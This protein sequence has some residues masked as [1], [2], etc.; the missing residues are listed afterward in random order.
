MSDPFKRP[1]SYVKN[2]PSHPVYHEEN[3]NAPGYVFS[4]MHKNMK[5]S[6]SSFWLVP[7]EYVGPYN[8]SGL[9][10][11]ITYPLPYGK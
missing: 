6:S 9:N 5:E 10:S 11:R 4:S 2:Y 8:H 3:G 1:A 7:A